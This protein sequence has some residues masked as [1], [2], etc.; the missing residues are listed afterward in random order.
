MFGFSLTNARDT[1]CF[2]VHSSTRVLLQVTVGIMGR[3]GR[4]EG[5]KLAEREEDTAQVKCVPTDHAALRR[6]EC[7]SRLRAV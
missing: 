4:L 1:F 7:F 6:S 5:Y 3:L 2:F